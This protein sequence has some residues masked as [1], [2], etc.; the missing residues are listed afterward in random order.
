MNS[1]L[2]RLIFITL[3]SLGLTLISSFVLARLLSVQDRGLHQ[4]FIT[5]V[6]Y[7]VTFATGGSGFALALSM[8][9]KQY[10]GWQNYFI[11]F[12]ALSV[13]AA[14]IAIYCFDFTAF[15]VL[16]VLN[17]VLTAILTMTLEKSKID[18]NLRVYRQLT[19]QQP[20]LL[21]AVYGIC[22]LLLGEQPLEIAIELFTLFSAM[23]ALAC[24][25]YLKKINA[26]FKRK[27]EIQPI[28]KRFFL[29]TWFKQNLLQIFGATTA[30]LDKFLI[31]YFLGNY[32]LGLYTVCIA[33]DSL[34]TKFINML[35]DYFYSGLLNNIN[36]I[37]SVLILILLMAVG[38]VILV[39]LLAEPIIIFFFS[40]KYAEVAPVLILFIINAIIGGLSWVLSQ[41][42]L[43][44]GKQVLLFTRQVI[45]IAVFV[46]LF[47]LFK[48]YQLYGVAY[49]FIGASLTRLIISVIYYLKYPITDVKPEKSAV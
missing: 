30:S 37:K 43:L 8:R 38:A 25:Y 5:A 49:A 4:L 26:D 27:N 19:L 29:K 41:N 9:K 24:L 12:L 15:H 35:A 46:L 34:I 16:F 48:D 40:A 17:V 22:Y 31:V 23:Q 36:R 14:I 2:I 28:Q 11:A 33:F 44:L 20:V 6:S 13:L 10:A 39:P 45:A 42:M 47:Y 32:T 7:V 3:L 18:A 21:V 1:N